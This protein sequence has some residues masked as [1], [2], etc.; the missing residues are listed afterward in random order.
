MLFQSNDVLYV[1]G[2]SKK[3]SEAINVFSS[4]FRK[5]QTTLP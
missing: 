3:I 5:E 4:S 1:L 2:S